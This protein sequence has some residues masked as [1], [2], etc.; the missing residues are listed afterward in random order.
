MITNIMLDLETLGTCPGSVILQIGAV[1]SNNGLE[2]TITIDSC[3]RAGLTVDGDTIGWWL[4]QSEAARRASL[5]C[6]LSIF[7]V[8]SVILWCGLAM[9][10]ARNP[11][12]R[13]G[14][15]PC[16]STYQ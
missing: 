8:L 15:T 16:Y 9:S 13:S 4:R 2:R 12:L 14:R 5:A 10:T 3:L 6:A 7:N 1:R 11:T